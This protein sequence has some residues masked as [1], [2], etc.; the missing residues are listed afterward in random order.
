M[1]LLYSVYKAVM[2]L[3]C[4]QTTSFLINI[5]SIVVVVVVSLNFNG[6]EFENTS[7]LFST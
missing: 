6:I 4:L 2:A 7:F 5:I 1:F 3:P